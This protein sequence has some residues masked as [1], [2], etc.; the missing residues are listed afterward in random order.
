M[1]KILKEKK[2]S[3]QRLYTACISNITQKANRIQRAG[4]VFSR[5]PTR[6]NLKFDCAPVKPCSG[7]LGSLLLGV[8]N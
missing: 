5:T 8:L 7:I 6:G 3:N 2:V 4:R 1:I